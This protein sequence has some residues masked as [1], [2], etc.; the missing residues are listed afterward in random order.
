[1][2][3]IRMKYIYTLVVCFTLFYHAPLYSQD[4][5][6]SREGEGSFLKQ[7]ED[8]FSVSAEKKTRKVF[9]KEVGVF[10]NSPETTPEFKSTILT[11]CDKIYE[12][13]GK[14]FPDYHDYLNA[15]MAFHLNETLYLSYNTWHNAILK[16][17]NQSN[18]QMRHAIPLF[19]YTHDALQNRVLYSTSAIQ[20]K[21]TSSHLKFEFSDSLYIATD[22]TDLY[23]ASPNDTIYVLKTKGR[24]NLMSGQWQGERGTITW[25]QS[26]FSADK[27]YAQFNAYTVNMNRNEIEIDSVTFRNSIYFNYPLKGRIHHKIVNARSSFYPKFDSYEQVYEIPNIQKDFNYEGGFSQ[28]GSKF[29]G[30]GSVEKPAKISIFKNDTLFITATSL[31]FSLREDQ[32]VSRNAEITI[33]LDSNYIYHPDV[34]FKYMVDLRELHL[35]RDG[36]GMAQSPFFN[37]YHNVSMKSQLLK[38]KVDDAIIEFR[39]LSG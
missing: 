11:V 37:I 24:I 23:C 32:I 4:G 14:P 19:R 13:K 25:E 21:S 36:K 33:H 8:V 39:M 1:M 5:F 2:N 12:R 20:W 27:V 7:L 6:F 31:Y 35:I 22:V 9:L 16:L 10:W 38:W 26:G 15:V 28:H 34:Y 30:S 18:F 3:Y 17:L 29:L